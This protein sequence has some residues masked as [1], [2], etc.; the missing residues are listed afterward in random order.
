[1]TKKVP[2]S[3]KFD[4]ALLERLDK[5]QGKMQFPATRTL[6]IEIAVLEMLDREEQKAKRK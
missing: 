1:M 3:L 4:A 5:F 2:I 6:L